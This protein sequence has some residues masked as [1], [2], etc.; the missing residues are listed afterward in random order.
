MKANIAI[1][2]VFR[3]SLIGG[4]SVHSSNLYE[5]LREDG[6][7]IIRFDYTNVTNS[8]G[9]LSRLRAII[10]MSG[11]LSRARLNG[12]RIFHFHSSNQA[13]FFYLFG[14][15]LKMTGANVIL[16]IHSGYGYDRWLEEHNY[17][18]LANH[19]LF[20]FLDQLIFMNPQESE[21]IKGRYPFLR[22]RITT[23]NPFIAPRIEDRPAFIIPNHIVDAP[24]RIVTIGAWRRRYNVE[25]AVTAALRFHDLTKIPVEITVLQSTPLTQHDYRV[26]LEDL[27]KKASGKISI[28]VLE[29]RNDV[30]DILAKN[31]VFIRPS[32]LDSYGLCVAESLLVGTPAIVTNVCK[33]CHAAH[34]YAQGDIDTLVSQLE[35]V[36]KERHLPRKSLLTA[37][38]DS[39][40][41]YR[42]LYDSFTSP[43]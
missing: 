24:Y 21:R 5:R 23:V 14:P 12:T 42:N 30:L 15:L 25:E 28:H 33:R 9:F 2:S 34:L 16:S 7:S 36:Y 29:D 19:L 31:D 39:Y 38:E 13:L 4:I 37:E 11:R 18:D 27:F 3:D 40:F 41:S 43:S 35:T 32:L 26:K 8:P 6:R 1:L 20:R 10:T 22:Q 17:F